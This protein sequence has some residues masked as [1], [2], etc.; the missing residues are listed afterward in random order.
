MSMSWLL[1]NGLSSLQQSKTCWEGV[2]QPLAK[3]SSSYAHYSGEKCWQTMNIFI[4]ISKED[5][6]ILTKKMDYVRIKEDNPEK[7]RQEKK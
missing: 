5:K 2:I 3:T 6:L 1:Y 4:L 7:L